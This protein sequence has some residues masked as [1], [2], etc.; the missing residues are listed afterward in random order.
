MAALSPF[1]PKQFASL[2]PIAGMTLATAESGIRYKGRPDLLLA[3]FEEGTQAVGV[4]TRSATAAAPVQWCRRILPAGAARALVVNAGNA[5]ACTGAPGMQAVEDV[6][7]EISRSY[8]CAPDRV[9]VASTGVIG[10]PLNTAKITGI[11]PAMGKLARPDNWESAAQAIMTT[12]TYPKLATRQAMLDGRP[13]TLNGIAKGSGMIAPDMATMLAFLFTDAAIEAPVLQALLTEANEES[14]NAITVDGDTSTNDTVLCFTT[15]AAGNNA[16]S[17]LEDR[18]LDGFRVALME[19][20]QDLALQVICDGEGITKLVSVEVTDAA[21]AGDA[22]AIAASIANSPLVKTAIAGSDP[23]WGRIMM[24]VGKAGVALQQEKL[25]LW[26]GDVPV[27]ERGCIHPAYTEE[28]GAA[29]MQGNSI[30]IQVSL[31]AGSAS[32][33]MWTCDLTHDYIS[34]NADYRS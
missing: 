22:R 2:P 9:Y 6:V 13:V 5:N 25:A 32:A 19:I 8:Y 29:Y 34:I 21:S 4:F 17:R 27:V 11:I 31:G 18:R 3:L 10:A 7:G 1:T 33:R 30:E 12:D 15:G 14:F 26:L 20:M 16:V 28:R 24:A 23:N